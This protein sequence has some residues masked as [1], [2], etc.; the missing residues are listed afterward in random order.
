MKCLVH[1]IQ[2]KCMH[3]IFLHNIFEQSC[4]TDNRK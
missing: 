2:I 3:P 1:Y 4:N